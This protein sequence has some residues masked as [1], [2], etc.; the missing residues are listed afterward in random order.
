[1]LNKFP[2]RSDGVAGRRV[3]PGSPNIVCNALLQPWLEMV[4]GHRRDVFAEPVEVCATPCVL[5]IPAYGTCFPVL[6]ASGTC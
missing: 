1:V 4:C 2:W 6:S 3:Q 5:V